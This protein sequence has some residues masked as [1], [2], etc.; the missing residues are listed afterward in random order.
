MMRRRRRWTS[1]SRRARRWTSTPRSRPTTTTPSSPRVLGDADAGV[2]AAAPD[3]D[4]DDFF[5]ALLAGGDDEDYVA[6]ALA[7][8]ADA[9]VDGVADARR[10]LSAEARSGSASRIRAAWAR[11]AAACDGSNEAPSEGDA[12]LAL[13]PYGASGACDEARTVLEDV[14]RLGRN[15]TAR[16]WHLALEAFSRAKRPADADRFL[17]AARLRGAFPARPDGRLYRQVLKHC[18]GAANWRRAL[19]VLEDMEA[20]KRAVKEGDAAAPGRILA[21]MA[22]HGHAPELK[23]LGAA[24]NAARHAARPDLALARLVGARAAAAGSTPAPWEPDYRADGVVAALDAVKR[25]AAALDGD[26]RA[27]R[28]DATPT[29][30]RPS[31][32]SSS[33]RAT[34][35]AARARARADSGSD[36]AGRLE[37]DADGRGWRSAARPD[38]AHAAMMVCKR[39]AAQGTGDWPSIQLYNAVLDAYEAAGRGDA[40]IALLDQLQ[41][42]GVPVDAVTYNICLRV[43]AKAGDLTKATS[44]LDEM[45]REVDEA[46]RPDVFSYTTVIRACCAPARG[47]RRR[48]HTRDDGEGTAAAAL[49]VLDRCVADARVD[50]NEVTFRTALR[51]CVG[52]PDD[53]PPPFARAIL[54]LDVLARMNRAGYRR[55]DLDGATIARRKAAA[56]RSTTPTTTAASPRAFDLPPAAPAQPAAPKPAMMAPPQAPNPYQMPMAPNPYGAPMAPMPM[57]P[58]PYGMPMAP[59]P[60]GAAPP[61]AMA[62]NLYGARVNLRM[63]ASRPPSTRRRRPRR[64]TRRRRRRRRRSTRRRRRRA[65]RPAARAYAHGARRRRRRL[66]RARCAHRRG[67][68]GV[69]GDALDGIGDFVS[70][71]GDAEEDDADGGGEVALQAQIAEAGSGDLERYTVAFESEVKLGMLLERRHSFTPGD[72]Q[73]NRPELTVVTMVIDGGAAERKGVVVGSKLLVINGVDA[74]KLPYAKCLDMVKT[75][76]RPL[77]L[78]LERSRASVDTA[79]GWCLVRKSAGTVAPSKMSAWKRM[80]FVVGGAVAKRHVLQLYATKAQYEDIVVRMFQGQPLTGF[81]TRPTRSRTPSVLQHP[82]EAVRRRAH[83]LKFFC[84]RNPYSRT[85]RSSRPTPV[86]RRRASPPRALRDQG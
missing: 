72:S 4:D 58:N 30:P 82:V 18:V 76:P 62:P 59:N 84:L 71:G 60:Y 40:A 53:D 8:A 44:L 54:G 35:T 5:A 86:R 78:V 50:P 73:E 13:R 51:A 55:S 15:G 42:D 39:R 11:F 23:A 34:T 75:L 19:H 12:C 48:R 28:G 49:D 9:A 66:R 69:L 32:C 64:S 45:S 70:G 61:P 47:G 80:Y 37:A 52:H 16:E 21:A 63:P 36:G 3:D 6:A 2:A 17:G 43:C 81:G 31:P 27:K 77:T 85:T 46:A 1:P 33:S 38:G 22:A 25:A 68:G 10:A 67:A 41:A 79:K 29:R 74:T 83:A 7:T 20:Q 26:A 56:P 65:E 14:E 24:V 57:A